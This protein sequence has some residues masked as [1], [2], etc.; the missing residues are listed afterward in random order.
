MFYSQTQETQNGQKMLTGKANKP[1]YFVC[2]TDRAEEYTAPYPGLI[3]LYRKN[4]FVFFKL[5]PME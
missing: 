4:G 5:D 1:C 2:K 3:E